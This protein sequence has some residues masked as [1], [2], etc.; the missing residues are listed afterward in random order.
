MKIKLTVAVPVYNVQKYLRRCIDSLIK[1]KVDEY[2]VLLVD[3]G[4]TDESGKICDEYASIYD[5]I[6]VIHQQNKG[7]AEVRNVCIKNAKG[8]FISFI[9]SDDFIG[10]NCYSHLLKIM[11][12][13]KADI[14]CY[15]VIDLY[16]G[17]EN[18]G[19]KSND[20][21]ETIVTLTGREALEEML[22]PKHVDV[23]TCNKIIRKSLYDGIY[24]PPGKLYEDMFT[25]Y[26]VI[27]KANKVV[28]TNYKYYYYYHRKGSIGRTAFNPKT[29][30]LARAT[31]EVFR[32]GKEFCGSKI[33]NLKVGRLFW[34]VVVINFMIKSNT[35][36]YA[37]IKEA[38]KFGKKNSLVI[39]KNSYITVTRKIQL[40]IF[41]YCFGLYKLLYMIYIGKKR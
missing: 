21:E 5:Y 41:S 23:I 33:D 35:Y 40:L 14:M 13:T 12:E 38:Q 3:D 22:L 2:E 39:V 31:D 28:S 15:G 25:N 27:A 16:E 1:N 24:Y 11:H 30:D 37:F 7:L 29:M 36:D 20:Y 6:R 17:Y 34:H 4:S 9:D 10:E 32:F 26:K 8:E 18:N 19:S